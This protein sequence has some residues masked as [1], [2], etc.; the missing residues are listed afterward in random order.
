MGANLDGILTRSSLLDLQPV[1]CIEVLM[2]HQDLVDVVRVRGPAGELVAQ[3]LERMREAVGVIDVD[4]GD[5]GGVAGEERELQVA[6]VI[7]CLE[8]AGG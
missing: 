8:A 7:G 3:H 6:L 1:A 5:P 4:V 2:L